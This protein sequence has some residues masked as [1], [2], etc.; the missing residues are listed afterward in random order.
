MNITDII[1]LAKAGYKPA[2]VREFLSEEK[3]PEVNAPED[4]QSTGQDPAA[5]NDQ[6][7]ESQEDATAPD[8]YISRISDLT[9]ANKKLMDQLKNLQEANSRQRQPAPEIKSDQDILNDLA[10][11][12]M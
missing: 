12:F 6:P 1:A 2:D 8:D 4:D 3:T 11:S 9:E 10:R 5:S 7:A